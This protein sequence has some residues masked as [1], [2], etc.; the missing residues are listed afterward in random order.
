MTGQWN[1]KAEM[2]VLEERNEGERRGTYGRIREEDGERGG[3][4]RSRTM[5]SGGATS[6]KGSHSWRIE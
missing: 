1:G 2:K 4:R 3:G 6:N 5:W